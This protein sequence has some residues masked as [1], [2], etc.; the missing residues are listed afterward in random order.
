MQTSPSPL[1]FN[2]CH[3]RKQV[4][5]LA[6][7]TLRFVRTDG[8]LAAHDDAE[9]LS[10][11]YNVDAVEQRAHAVKLDH[12]VRCALI[13]AAFPNCVGWLAGHNQEPNI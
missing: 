9:L 6:F 11:T 13:L 10:T 3:S 8:R 1:T 4:F 2:V 7:L 12:L 5:S